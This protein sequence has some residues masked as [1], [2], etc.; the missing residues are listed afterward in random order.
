APSVRPRVLIVLGDDV[1]TGDMAP[2]GALGI[3][4]WSNIPACAEFM[5]RRTDPK[6]HQRSLEWGGGIIVAGHN[7]GQGSSREQA[8]LS[9]SHLGIR[10]VVAKSFARIHR[11]NLIAQGILPLVFAS[12]DDHDAVAVGDEWLIEDLRDAVADAAVTVSCRTGSGSSIELGIEL[13]QREREILLAGG[14]LGYLRPASK[15]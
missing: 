12:E 6:F 14:M 2:D 10:T 11:Q 4:L 3:A 13:L 1:S 9:A 15:R 5:F 7:Y 8:A